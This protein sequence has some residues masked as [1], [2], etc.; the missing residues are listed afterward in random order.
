MLRFR[1]LYISFTIALRLFCR[2]VFMA[3][4]FVSPVIIS[5]VSGEIWRPVREKQSIPVLCDHLSIQGMDD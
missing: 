2:S 5:Q 1:F 4:Y 3:G